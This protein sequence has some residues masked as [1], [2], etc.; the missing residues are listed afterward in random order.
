[1]LTSS[2]CWGRRALSLPPPAPFSCSP[3]PRG[4]PRTG[5]EGLA[6][7]SSYKGRPA[8]EGGSTADT[9]QVYFSPESGDRARKRAAKSKTTLTVCAP[10]ELS[11]LCKFPRGVDR[12]PLNGLINNTAQIGAQD[13]PFLRSTTLKLY[14]IFH[15]DSAYLSAK[16]RIYA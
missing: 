9:A 7:R 4:C 13:E 2:A 3:E 1:M 16:S 14:L 10:Q 12:S 15:L 5:G 8:A 11:P 6:R